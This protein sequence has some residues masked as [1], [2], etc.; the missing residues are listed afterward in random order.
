MTSPIPVPKM[1]GDRRIRN[2]I[3][4]N[5]AISLPHA[6]S[7]RSSVTGFSDNQYDVGTIDVFSPRPTI[8][9]SMHSQMVSGALRSAVASRT[10]SRRDEEGSPRRTLRESKTIDDLA[11]RYDATTLRELME[12]DAKRRERRRKAEGDKARRRLERHAARERGETA[13]SSR[14]KR[15]ARSPRTEIA[16]HR[17]R[18]HES[19]LGLSGVDVTEGPR[20]RTPTS[21]KSPR[22]PVAQLEDERTA[23]KDTEDLSQ[24][25]NPFIDPLSEVVTPM[26]EPIVETAEEIRYS[27]ASMSPP[28]S[29]GGYTR[30]PSNYSQTTDPRSGSVTN[31]NEA[32]PEERRVSETSARRSG[33]LAALLR[34]SAPPG[35]DG[36]EKRGAAVEPS[37]SNTSRES[38]KG[39][40]LQ[41]H[42]R[43]QRQSAPA[44][45]SST[46]TRTMSKFREDLPEYSTTPPGSRTGSP[47]E[48]PVPTITALQ[49]SKLPESSLQTGASNREDP[50]ARNDSLVSSR[51]ML[52]QSLASVDSEGSWLSGKPAKRS[53]QQMT[54]QLLSERADFNGSYENLGVSDEE[55][56]RRQTTLQPQ[57]GLGGIQAALKRDDQVGQTSSG[58]EVSGER[59]VRGDVSRRPT[60]VQQEGRKLS[61]EGLLNQFQGSEAAVVEGDSKQASPSP[62]S[63]GI[64]GSPVEEV[65]S[66]TQPVLG[67]AR[68]VSRQSARLMEIPSRRGSPAVKQGEFEFKSAEKT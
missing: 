34:R 57:S 4:N 58:Q 6:A 31:L 3:N 2:D 33:P 10:E 20:P 21:P 37:F 61:Q 55:Y 44:A 35:R 64:E 50:E 1:P 67:H 24:P 53:S 16:E 9:Y 28:A 63:A 27:Q 45:R 52:S 13:P 22:S 32:I 68:S 5:S 40:V 59:I 42:L 60:V 19:G 66:P 46:P 54:P 11:E 49:R 14:S 56:F 43:E 39:Q 62:T 48:P 25:P 26:D 18:E 23:V 36:N 12:R 51:A 47:A 17:R 15:R 38:M 65:D 29:P 41:G 7:F 8:R 30:K